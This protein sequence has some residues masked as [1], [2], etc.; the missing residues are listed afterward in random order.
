MPLEFETRI[1]ITS[2]LLR[3]P[4]LVQQRVLTDTVAL[5]ETDAKKLQSGPVLHVQSGFLSSRTTGQLRERPDGWDLVLGNPQL[6]SR[7]LEL[8]GTTR[9]H[10][11][12]ARSPGGAL[13]FTGRSGELVIRRSVQ[14]P[15][16]RIEPHPTLQ[17]ALAGQV[18]KIDG[19]IA[20]EDAR[21][22]G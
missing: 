20:R 17:P 3:A 10:Q 6:Y 18:A 14:H 19:R 4:R 11:I 8:G 5:A 16:S 12:V 15:G 13:A 1:E 7:I 2:G 9:P 21:G 22:G